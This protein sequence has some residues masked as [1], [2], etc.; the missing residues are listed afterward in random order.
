MTTDELLTTDDILEAF[1]TAGRVLPRAALEQAVAR[2]EEVAPVL[3][4][5]LEADADRAGRS[6]RTND[7]LFFAIYLVAQCRETRACRS[8]CAIAADE[9]RLSELIE[10]GVT[11][12]LPA[13]LSR[14]WGTSP[15]TIR[16][17]T[18]GVMILARAAAARSSRNAAWKWRGKVFFPAILNFASH[19]GRE[20]PCLARL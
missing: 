10:D 19:G 13:I 8:L 15:P 1:A 14:V 2:W 18:L 12:D 7:I 6:E 11:G 4:S 17:G 3:V 9:E 16:T 20:G 5:M